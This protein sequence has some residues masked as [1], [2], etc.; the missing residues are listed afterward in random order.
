[1][2]STYRFYSY[3]SLSHSPV[4]FISTVAFLKALKR[5]SLKLILWPFSLKTFSNSY[6]FFLRTGL[7]DTYEKKPILFATIFIYDSTK[8]NGS[9]VFAKVLI[10]PVS[11]AI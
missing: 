11:L 9:K 8:A 6:D 4:L 3:V 1:M 7:V 5:S 10:W 2:S